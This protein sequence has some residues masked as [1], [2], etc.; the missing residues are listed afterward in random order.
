MQ[1]S[2]YTQYN[3]NIPLTVLIIATI[4]FIFILLI[5]I[6]NIKPE[7]KDV[8][9]EYDI[10]ISG[11]RNVDYDE[12]VQQFIIEEGYERIMKDYHI[13]LKQW[14]QDWEHRIE[15]CWN[16]EDAKKIYNQKLDKI[17]SKDCEV[18][19]INF[20][21]KQ[22]R[23]V[24]RNYRRVAYDVDNVDF[25]YYL[26][27]NE[28]QKLNEALREIDYETTLV[29]YHSN[30]QRKL[31]TKE[32]K[33]KIKIRDNYTCQICGKYMPDEIGLHIDHII[34]VK[35]GGKTI[36]SNLQVLCSRC[37]GQKSDKIPWNASKFE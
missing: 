31:L 2:D 16:K 11:K 26:S 21:R 25:E 36:P 15:S 7:P 8:C 20:I 34:P 33:E 32:L 18:F 9:E 19:K 6:L 30:N 3:T 4:V 28:L 13:D 1:V 23:Y 37:N 35:A 29:K 12:Y 22:R 24:Q 17:N 14:R 27:I 5:H 10:D